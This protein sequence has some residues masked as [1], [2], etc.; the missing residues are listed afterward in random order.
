M[1]YVWFGYASPRCLLTLSVGASPSTYRTSGSQDASQVRAAHF[2]VMAIITAG[3]G[4]GPLRA[5]L[6]PLV[7]AFDALLGVVSGD[8]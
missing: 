1:G 6:V 7:A 3:H 2:P 4:R 8:I 5:L